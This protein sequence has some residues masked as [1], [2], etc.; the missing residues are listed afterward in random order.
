M[1]QIYWM[2]LG[3]KDPQA[4]AGIDLVAIEDTNNP[5]STASIGHWWLGLQVSSLVTSMVCH[6]TV[7]PPSIELD[8][9]PH[10][11]R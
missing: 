6:A 2:S 3:H 9:I 7:T 10:E 11:R 1:A 4:D 5:E 8:G